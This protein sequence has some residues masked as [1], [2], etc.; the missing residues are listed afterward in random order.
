MIT[1]H[2]FKAS[3]LVRAA[4]ALLLFTGTS[5]AADYYVSK[6]G[7]D[8]NSGTSSSPWLTLQHAAGAVGPGDVVHVLD[9]S[10]AGMNITQ[11]G[12]AS[13]PITFKADGSN[14]RLTTRNP[15]TDD[16][17]NIEG[18]DYI[19]IDG[20]KVEDAP[21]IG[22][23]IVQARGVVI[24]NNEVMR[25]GHTGILTGWT[26]EIQ[27]LN[28]VSWGAGAQHGIYVSNSN[29]AN[30]NVVI[31]GNESYGN[32]QNGVQLNG[33]CWEGGD[34]IISGAII[35]NNLVHD[36]NW[37]G[38][39][40]ISVRNSIIRNNV[41]YDNGISAGAGGI[42]LADQPDCTHESI[43]NV[44]VN[45]T[46]VEPR[47]AGMRMTDDSS[48]NV[49]FNNLVVA[50]SS[51]YTIVD[52]VGGNLVD[53]STNL[54]YTSSSGLFVN[55]GA[56]DYH[57]TSSSPAVDAG[58]SGYQGESAPN[59]D[60]E[61]KSRPVGSAWDSGAYEY[62]TAVP[63][64]TPPTVNVTS[65]ADNET[66]FGQIT[67]SANASDNLGVAGVQF[68][69]DG[70]NVGAE[71]Q[72]APYQMTLATTSLNNGVHTVSALARDAAGNSAESTGVTINVDNAPPATG[73][74]PNHPRML[75]NP[76]RLAELRAAACR[77]A[78]GNVIPGCT[79]TPQW[80]TLRDYVEMCYS[81]PSNCYI[82]QP[83]AFALYY[84]MTGNVNYANRAIS[85][86]NSQINNGF[87]DERS[88]FYLH[89]DD[90]VQDAAFV[91][92]W[93]YDLL[94]PQQRSDYIDYMNR[95]VQEIYVEDP[96][97][98]P[99]YES[100][101]W[102]TN[103]PGNNY[104]YA[105]L[106]CAVMTALSTYGENDYTVPLNG[107]D[108]PLELYFPTE[109]R[110]YND[111]L[112]FVYARL[113]VEA[114]GEWI[115]Y[116]G[117]GGGWHEGTQYGTAAKNQIFDIYLFLREAGAKD[118]FT[119][120]S[121]PRAAARFFLYCN[122][123]GN[124]VR[125]NGGDAGRDKEV[126]VCPYQRGT[127]LQLARGLAGTVESEYMQY[128]ANH[129]YPDMGTGWQHMYPTDFLHTNL[130]L[131]ERNWYD[132]P[133]AYC[134]G[135]GGG[136]L[137]WMNSRSSWDPDAVSV[138]F[139]CADRVQNHQHKDQNTFVIFKGDG[140][141]GWQAIDANYCSGSN[142]LYK[143]GYLHNT[144][145]VNNED[146]RYG[147]GTG[148]V[149]RYELTPEYS[150]VVGDATDAYWTNP[151]GY[152]HG[153]DPY[154]DVFQRELVHA[155]PNYVVVYDRVT[156]RS[157]F[158][159]VPIA[160]VMNTQNTPTIN[161]NTVTAENGGNKI[162]QKT[163]LPESDFTI[164][165]YNS[166]GCRHIELKRNSP[167]LHTQFLN[168]IWVGSS[169]GSMPATDLV[170]STTDNMVGAQIKESGNNIVLMFSADPYG[171]APQGS[172]IYELSAT[173]DTHNYLYGL[174]PE[175][176]YAIDVVNEPGKQTIVVTRG[177]GQLTTTQGTLV[178]DA[179]YELPP[180]L[181]A[182][183]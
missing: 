113:E 119:T 121:F 101:R 171:S 136:G 161:G 64:A 162:I 115:S 16:I 135:S 69:V 169:S 157:N 8:G 81:T 78:N 86:T 18:G 131:S 30:D 41:I 172:V 72:Q 49:F 180:D 68:L 38:F 51:D 144:L 39:S 80:T 160:Y 62:G 137:G 13:Q 168:V 103:D 167:T 128:W 60:V 156:P 11:D 97:H 24:K 126:P 140:L 159:S 35:E 181:M 149:L 31:S 54:L 114:Q 145:L 21:R 91:Y 109:G 165:D 45:N 42:H 178:F 124:E 110:I 134:T 9:G 154:L 87:D 147:D 143:N 27:I 6:S 106:L 130:S 32:G 71:V 29:E 1:Q 125:Y 112:E 96:L 179:A 36:N 148:E 118:Y 85:L 89:A 141:G 173:E 170:T 127:A 48:P 116:R 55:A 76:T 122:Q 90:K 163:L 182:S 19:V 34:G 12:T 26:P 93:L 105:Q 120:T 132:Q 99:F 88:N 94:T 111:M 37:K 56:S 177:R 65:P 102:A 139:I 59:V 33:D 50:K 73:I 67:L 75:L 10:Y 166:L 176:E 43:N 40:L 58:A 108:L 14:V 79:P 164:S 84:M 23:R 82:V 5:H 123:P 46:V 15:V 44:I 129:I 2:R 158:A 74:L 77:D 146:Q 83:Y 107:S 66:V 155:L 104:Y 70:S 174:V 3:G 142:G 183:K 98:N 153:D 61:G 152:S 100:D 138:T 4:I 175:T 28:N 92:D 95:L 22:I 133:T 47:I 63:D 150:Y 151:S 52:E 57:L 7:G 20:F 117:S 53:G 25:S 17:V